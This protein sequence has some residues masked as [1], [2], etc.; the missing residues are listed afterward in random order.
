MIGLVQ[1]FVLATLILICLAPA[2]LVILA[3][4]YRR[5]GRHATALAG[6][7]CAVVGFLAGGGA[8]WKLVAS[9]WHLS[10]L[11]TVEAAVNAEKYGHPVEHTAENILVWVLFGGVVAGLISGAG[12][13]LALR[14]RSRLRRA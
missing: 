3:I 5:T 7:C 2:A 13:A 9:V 4:E 11:T 8:V 14:T 10:F 12:A 1:M 6:A